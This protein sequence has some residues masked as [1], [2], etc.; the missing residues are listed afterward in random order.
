M[1]LEIQDFLLKK[2]IQIVLWLF[3]SILFE[4]EP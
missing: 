2:T 4:P 1:A 3:D